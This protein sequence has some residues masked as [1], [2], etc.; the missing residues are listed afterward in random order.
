M[1]EQIQGIASRV[2]GQIRSGITQLLK[3][4]VPMDQ[5]SPL[6]DC[7][8]KFEALAGGPP[9][10]APSRNTKQGIVEPE[11]DRDLDEDNR[12]VARNGGRKA[13]AKAP[14]KAA[15]ASKTPAKSSR[16]RGK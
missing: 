14:A 3:S 13:P 2:L 11:L 16:G 15:T 8:S 10:P 1:N 4:G 9:A 12:P 5:V 6:V 7:A